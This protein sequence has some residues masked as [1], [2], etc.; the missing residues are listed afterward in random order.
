MAQEYKLANPE[1]VQPHKDINMSQGYG[2]PSHNVEAKS[3]T[4]FKYT[5]YFLIH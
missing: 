2:K 3:F 1:K 4:L 5:T